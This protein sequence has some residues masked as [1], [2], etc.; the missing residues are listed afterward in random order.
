MLLAAGSSRR[1]GGINKLLLPVGGVPLVR[2]AARVLLRAGLRPVVVVVGAGADAIRE[3]LDGLPVRLVEN[4][5][6]L[7]GMGTSV[8]AGVAALGPEAAA[9]A[10]TVADLP[11]L[12]ARD[13]RTVAEALAASERGIAVPVWE[14]RRGHPVFFA[15]GPYRQLL[16][17]LGGDE[18]ARGIL[19]ARPG[20]VLEVAVSH[21]GGFDDLDTPEAYRCLSGEGRP[22]ARGAGG[23]RP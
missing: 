14:G 7:E 21:P 15:L 20:D 12:R 13:V 22:G 2:R 4:P 16:E 18:G 3:A 8:A 11:R 1:M 9:V 5:R 17:G 10:V 23:R 19:R 6:H